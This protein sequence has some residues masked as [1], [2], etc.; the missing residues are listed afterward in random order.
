MPTPPATSSERASALAL[1]GRPLRWG[2][3]GL[4]IL[5][6]CTALGLWLRLGD[7]AA[8]GFA[9]DEVHK[10]LAANRYLAGD[11][12]G[13][14]LEHPMLMKSLIALVLLIG[15]RLHWAPEVVTRLPNAV[16]GAMAVIALAFL[17]RR[18]FGRIAGLFA[19]AL[20]AF[21]VS[22]IGYQRIAKEDI[23]LGLFV[24][25]LCLCIAEAKASID[26]G[27]HKRARRFELGG[28][29]A[30]AA[31]MAT[32]YYPYLPFIPVAAILW[33]SR[34][35]TAYRVTLKRWVQLALFSLL[36]WVCL[37]WMVLRTSTWIYMFNYI[38]RAKHGGRAT[39]VTMQ[40]MGRLYGQLFPGG[41]GRMPS[42][43]Y[44]VF[45]AVK[46]TPGAFLLCVGGLV[47]AIAKRYPS[48]RLVLAWMAVWF[49]SHSIISGV[50]YARMFV[51]IFPA[52]F[53]LAG[54]AADW[55]IVWARARRSAVASGAMAGLLVAGSIVPELAASISH[56]PHFR[57]YISPLGGGDRY[58]T[59]YFPHCDYFD[60]GFREAME[61]IAHNAERQAEVSSEIDWTARYYAERSGREDFLFTML[62]PGE[63]CGHGKVCYVVVQVGRLYEANRVAVEAL[64]HRQPWHLVP[65]R[66]VEVVKVYRLNAAET[67]FPGSSQPPAS[68]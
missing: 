4:A 62:R 3:A 38:G 16:G 31:A 34:T 33:I 19:A 52:F 58:V 11:F 60:A 55:L 39:H 63:A 37:N 66:G 65:I 1:K 25:L 42:F 41:W 24:L 17:G 57:L 44:L 56:A 40:F 8:E 2:P 9:D 46:Q 13:D 18:L 28:A 49:A 29:L 23:L 27:E 45:L 53:L 51:P 15:R 26:G 54:S 7:L 30:L 32:K 35:D 12:G 21:S 43:F 47:W 64:S 68:E 48:Q 61:Y 22:W 50:K 5:A 6:A 14:D 67:P 20:G 59:W 36:C 10:W